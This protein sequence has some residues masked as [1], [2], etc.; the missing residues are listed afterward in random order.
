[1][2]RLAAYWSG[3]AMKSDLAK[4]PNIDY[5]NEVN[6][7]AKLSRKALKK[8]NDVLWSIDARRDTTMDL[9]DKM[10]EHTAELCN[11]AGI[12]YVFDISGINPAPRR[13]EIRQHIY[14][15]FKEAINNVVKHSE[16]Y[17]GQCGYSE[18]PRIQIAN[19]GQWKRK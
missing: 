6:D 19:S 11:I 18:S 13:S 12:V 2:T 16:G 10:K 9:I 1:M 14:L 5:A 4:I 15:I 8:M 3:I 7:I 17:H